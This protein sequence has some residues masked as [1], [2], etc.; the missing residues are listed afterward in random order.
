MPSH[1]QEEHAMVSWANRSCDEFEPFEPAVGG[2]LG[3]S[4]TFAL[5]EE[6]KG[7]GVTE[8]FAMAKFARPK[9]SNEE[10]AAV[11][12]EDEEERAEQ[13][14]YISYVA[15]MVSAQCGANIDS[16]QLPESSSANGCPVYR[17]PHAKKMISGLHPT[18]ILKGTEAQVKRGIEL[19]QNQFSLSASKIKFRLPESFA[20]DDDADESLL[21]DRID[22]G[23][24]YDLAVNGEYLDAMVTVHQ[25]DAL[26]LACSMEIHKLVSF[27]LLS[28]LLISIL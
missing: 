9:A 26:R 16:F 11:G 15:R 5:T 24:K 18:F 28:C 12:E 2:V 14:E 4:S 27:I 13:R 25:A 7:E 17:T 23:R 19:I 1:Y 6:K 21:F 8:F 20:Y 3:S 22:P 10:A